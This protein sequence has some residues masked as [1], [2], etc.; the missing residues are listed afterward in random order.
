MSAPSPQARKSRRATVGLGMELAA[1]SLLRSHLTDAGHLNILVVDDEFGT[2]A[3]LGIVLALAG[4]HAV[5]A[6]DGGQALELCEN[7]GV[8]FDLVIT[9]HQMFRASGL[10]LVRGL[11]Q[12]GFAGD[13]VVLTGYAGEAEKQEYR[14]LGVT[15]I[16][17]KP[18]KIAELRRWIE[19][20]GEESG[21]P[22]FADVQTC[23]QF[24]P[25]QSQSKAGKN[26]NLR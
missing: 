17:E 21:Y 23:P 25:S 14:K 6:R 1:K 15:G 22:R 13:I 5:F 12:K 26:Q 24:F 3:S 4:H 8:K 9:D 16:L 10:D 7:D 20:R 18:F 2:R 19:S 11:R